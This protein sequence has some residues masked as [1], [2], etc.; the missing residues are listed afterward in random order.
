MAANTA[1]RHISVRINDL[2]LSKF[3][4]TRRT[5]PSQIPTSY[6]IFDG[7]VVK[8]FVLW[9][10]KFL[11]RFTSFSRKDIVMRFF[12]IGFVDRWQWNMNI[13]K[14]VCYQLA[15]IVLSFTVLPDLMLRDLQYLNK[16][17]MNV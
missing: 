8:R 7:D 14:N 5:A 6:N 4:K 16:S 12:Y 9:N 13:R 3:N 11:E 10:H 17:S 15:H 2:S 1:D